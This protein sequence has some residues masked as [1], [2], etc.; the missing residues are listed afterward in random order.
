MTCAFLLPFIRFAVLERIVEGDTC[1]P[2]AEQR[3]VR[4]DYSRDLC[5]QP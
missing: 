3:N 1:S 2:S 4:D 5:E